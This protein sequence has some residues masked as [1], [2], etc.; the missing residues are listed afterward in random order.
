VTT[1]EPRTINIPE[2]RASESLIKARRSRFGSAYECIVCGLPAPA[3]KFYCH[4]IEG[5]GVALHPDDEALYVPDGGDMCN[6]P[7]GADC[8]RRNPQLKPYATKA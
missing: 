2:R 6:L 8:L 1:A 4:V 7:V 3:P 5:G